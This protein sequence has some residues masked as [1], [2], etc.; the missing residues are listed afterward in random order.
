MCHPSAER[1]N[2]E[3][4]ISCLAR[5]QEARRMPAMVTGVIKVR[6]NLGIPQL[7][8]LSI[9]YYRDSDTKCVLYMPISQ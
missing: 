9:F 3:S 8:D 4:H 2:N 5:G 1:Q 6:L 7:H